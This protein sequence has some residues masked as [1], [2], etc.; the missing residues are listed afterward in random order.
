MPRAD[1]VRTP[2]DAL[3]VAELRKAGLSFSEDADRQTLVRRAYLDLI[4]LPP[5]PDEV[6]AYVEATAADAYEQMVDRLL[7]SEHYGERWGRHWLDVAGYADTEGYTNADAD[8]PWAYF[9]RDYVIRSMNADKRFDVFLQEQLAGDEMVPRPYANLSAEAIEKLTATG[10]LR[11]AADGTGSGANDEEARN[12][13]VADTI[14]IVS[15]ALLG[16][17]VGCAQC[18]DHRYDP[19]S[20]LDYYQLRGGVCPGVAP[21]GVADAGGAAGVA[22]YGCG[23]REGGR[24]GGR[25]ADDRRGRRRR[26][27][28]ST[29]T[30]RWRRNWRSTRKRCGSRWSRRTGPAGDARTEAQKQLLAQ[31]PSVN[32]TAGNL[33]QYNQGHADELKKFD[34]RIGEV[35]G[36]EAGG[37]ILAGAVRAAGRGAGHAGVSSGRLPAADR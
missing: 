23:S 25:S 9:Y 7:E 4:G 17:S 28:R 2:I 12:Q 36:E 34:A 22:V 11:M 18:H 3:L 31:Y 30:R 20:Q 10:F 16:L 32:I 19:I 24:G 33:Y 13:T 14:K 6:Q 29:W 27:K 26:N 8:R 1:R 15:T 21:G 35:L 37:A 5:T